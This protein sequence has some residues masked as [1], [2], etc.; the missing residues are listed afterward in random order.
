[1]RQRVFGRR[2]VLP[3]SGLS[4]G[5]TLFYLSLVVL[6]PLGGLFWK[7][8]ELGWADFLRI[9]GSERARAAYA[10]TF[11]A[12]FAAALINGVFGLVLAWV[13]VRYRFP[14]RR[15]LDA[16]VDFPLALP[17]AVAG[18]AYTALY[19]PQGWIGRYFD[20]LGIQVS[21]S[22]LGVV[23]V[24]TFISLPFMVRTVQPVLLAL[25]R[26]V[27][28]AAASLGAGRWATVRRVILPALLP[29]WSTGLA[30]AFARA[31]GEYGSVIF[32]AGNLPRKTEI[33]PLLIVFQLE[34][35]NYAGATA[36]AV[37]LLL[38]SF[39]TVG[40]INLLSRRQQRYG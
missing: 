25:E 31:I 34:E 18:L 35:F 27:E 20:L 22:R 30:M 26:E 6:I 3:G 33:A 24:L 11:S 23:V 28:E 4:L 37:V 2:R 40:V 38:A 32:I 8:T 12:S 19:V 1:M 36:I 15:L 16:L 14:G 10:L 5:F 21:Y 39:F 29:A 13:L 7:S 9:A 17:T